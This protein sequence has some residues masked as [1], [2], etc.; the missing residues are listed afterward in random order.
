MEM[1]HLYFSL[2]LFILRSEL[3]T[4]VYQFQTASEDSG[5]DNVMSTRPSLTT[6][7]LSEE[8]AEPGNTWVVLNEEEGTSPTLP[9]GFGRMDL[10]YQFLSIFSFQTNDPKFFTI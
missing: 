6:L 7:S 2:I 10:L 4:N 3:R 9:L 1:C 5:R 8:D